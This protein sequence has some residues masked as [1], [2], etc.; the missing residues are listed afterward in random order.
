MD[1]V[2][3]TVS[4]TGTDTNVVAVQAGYFRNPPPVY[5][6]TAKA[7]GWEGTTILRVCVSTTGASSAVE[8]HQSSGYPVLDEAAV[9]AVRRWRFVPARENKVA[10]TAWVEVPVTFVLDR[11]S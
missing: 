11:E 9:R 1:S 8:V 6:P 3:G 10:V 7:Q 4:G 2:A 5:P